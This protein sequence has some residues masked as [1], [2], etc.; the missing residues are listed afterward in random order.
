MCKS[1]KAKQT[2]APVTPLSKGEP[3]P[4]VQ[5]KSQ[6]GC[7]FVGSN[8]DNEPAIPV[9]VS[10]SFGDISSNLQIIPDTGSDITVI[11][12]THLDTLNIP[13][14]RLFRPVTDS[15]T[16]D[17]SFF[18]TPAVGFFRATLHLG[19]KSCLATIH[20][21]EGF[22]NALLG[23]GHCRALAIIS[24][25]FPRPILEVTHVNS[26]TRIPTYATKSPEAAK[27]YFLREFNDVLVSKA[28]LQTQPLK[29]MAGPPMR[30]HLKP[31][32]TPFAEHT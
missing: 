25:E 1:T 27:E 10:V 7:R 12:T 20:V 22:P 29:K 13:R 30:I 28:D 15:V 26:C 4:P 8:S 21:N 5:A 14:S 16:A 17:G 2:G 18:K 24:E 11:G 6:T 31:G 32:A 23:R 9:D 3:R 19:D